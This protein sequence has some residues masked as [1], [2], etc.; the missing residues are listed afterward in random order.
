[1][2]QLTKEIRIRLG[3]DDQ[4]FIYTIKYFGLITKSRPIHLK[5]NV[6]RPGELPAR[7]A[8]KQEE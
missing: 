6:P 8:E 7:K 3:D 1:M 5:D 4:S 2:P